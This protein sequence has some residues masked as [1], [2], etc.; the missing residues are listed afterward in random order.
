MTQEI[1]NRIASVINALDHTEVKGRQNM[2]NIVG[3]IEILEDCIR[4]L[5]NSVSA[6]GTDVKQ[7]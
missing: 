6:V 7:E 1:I 4:A 5:S 3:G 2:M